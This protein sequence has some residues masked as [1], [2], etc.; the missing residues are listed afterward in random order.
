MKRVRKSY[1]TRCRV[2]L[3][4]VRTEYLVKGVCPSCRRSDP[5]RGRK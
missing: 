3:D 4:R 5:L 1:T 2:C